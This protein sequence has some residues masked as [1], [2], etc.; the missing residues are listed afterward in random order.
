M[1]NM[2]GSPWDVKLPNKQRFCIHANLRSD[3]ISVVAVYTK[4]WLHSTNRVLK[5]VLVMLQGTRFEAKNYIS[6]PCPRSLTG[7]SF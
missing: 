1:V 6:E 7:T 2:Y 4:D 5:N 3:V